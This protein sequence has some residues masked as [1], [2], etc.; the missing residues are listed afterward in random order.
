MKL[1]NITTLFIAIATLAIMPSC[2]DDD[3]NLTPSNADV[4]GFAPAEGDN[5]TTAQIRNDFFKATGSYLLFT[6]TLASTSSN[7]M[8][9]LF[10]ATYELTGSAAVSTDISNYDYK[11]AYITN[12]ETQRL[13]ANTILQTLVKKLGKQNPFSF[14]IVDDI[15]Y[16]YTTWSGAVRTTHV[17]MLLAPRGYV[18]STQDGLL[19]EN[20]DSLV[21]TLLSDIVTDRVK[22]ADE[23]TLAPFLEYSSQYYGNDFDD[24]GLDAA[25]FKND[26]TLI[27]NY[28]MFTYGTWSGGY[29]YSQSRDIEQWIN[30]VLEQDRETFEETYG[31]SSVMMS[32][33]D[34]LKEVIKNMGFNI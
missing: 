6:D 7:G 5:S 18:I 3:D 13:A 9:E 23:T 17:P 12:P 34:T 27:W 30:A 4:N 32:K 24:M 8:P 20:P 26:P 1:H 16:Q 11:Y 29:F 22:K 31:A 14:L 21:Q 25:D 15:S 19:Y 2:N 10:D 33:Y 28:G